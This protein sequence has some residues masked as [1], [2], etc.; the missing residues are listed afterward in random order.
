MSAEKT[1]DLESMFAK[2]ND[3]GF[4]RPTLSQSEQGKTVK[5]GMPAYKIFHA[6]TWETILRNMIA[7]R[8]GWKPIPAQKMR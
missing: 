8:D 1:L 7:W 6:R 2:L 5:L 4:D 3:L